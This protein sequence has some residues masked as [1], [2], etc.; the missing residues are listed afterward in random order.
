MRSLTVAVLLAFC[1]S[2]PAIADPGPVGITIRDHAFV[3]A[4]VKIPAGAKVELSI[5]NEQAMPA[6]FES[7]SLNR[8]K[9][10]SP[11]GAISVY[12]GP[13]SPGRYEFFDDFHP[14]TRGFIVAE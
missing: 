10:V 7:S 4:E 13:L 2:V 9:V 3:P 5:R 6:E 11:G 8:E 1:V 12:V 14:A